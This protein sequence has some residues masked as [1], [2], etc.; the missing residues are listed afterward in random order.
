MIRTTIT[1]DEELA[2]E[3][4]A[5]VARSAV[6]NRSEAIRDLVRRGLAAGPAKP[7]DTL[8]IGVISCAMEQT[9]PEL[10]RRVR[11]ARLARHDEIRFVTSV[12]LNHRETIDLIVLQA[13]VSRIEELADR[14]SLERG[15]RHATV[16]LIPIEEEVQT[17]A[18]DDEEP[19]S[20]SHL[21]VQQNF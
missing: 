16:G 6:P 17:H 11:D 18:H 8:C 1:L 13:S 15:V 20:H 19:H 2:A 7:A 12:P 21:R 5:H 3:I 14:L 4:D 9:L 10:S